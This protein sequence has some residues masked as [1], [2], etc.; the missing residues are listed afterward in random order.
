MEKRTLLAVV[1]S[2]LVI[3]A[4]Q[5]FLPSQSPVQPPATATPADKQ[6]PAEKQE[7]TPGSEKLIAPVDVPAEVKEITVDTDLYSAIFTTKGGTLK[8]WDLKGY[9]YKDNKKEKPVALVSPGMPAQPVYIQ[10][11]GELRD[12]PSIVN[13]SVDKDSVT[14]DSNSNTLT[15]YYADSSKGLSIKKMFTFYKDSFK[16]DLATEV[17]GVQS[18]KVALGSGFGIFDREGTWVHI[19]PVLLRDSKKIDLVS[20]NLEDIGTIKKWLTGKKSSDTV[21]YKGNIRWIAEEDKY[22]TSA[23]VSLSKDTEAVVW[24]RE[25]AGDSKNNGA[26]IAYVVNGEK[27]DF[28]L[29]AGPKRYELLKTFNVG[30]EHIIDFGFFSIIARPL[31]WLLKFFY[32]VIG[33]YGWAIIALT[34]VTRIPFIPLINKGQKSMKKLQEIQPHMTAL[35]EKY[36]NDPQ[37]MQKEV[38]E[39]Y[40]KHKVNPVGGCLPMLIQLP[41]FFALY[42]ILLI[43]IEL[44]GTPFMWWI[45]DLSMK[46]PYYILPIIMGITMVIQQKMTPS[47]MDPTQAKM[48]ML[49]P[50][51]FTFM[52]LSFP[53]G[54]VIYWL[55]SNVL[56]IVQQYYVNKKAASSA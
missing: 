53:S 20:G 7:I 50:V 22:F 12:L 31:F 1:L 11:D 26:D 41:V 8:K 51:I 35:K 34:V 16:V 36:K 4:S 29:Y 46:D 9:S 19:G 42:K 32:D 25:N 47:T 54:L 21:Q 18:Y 24:D 33:N 48:M 27:G 28:L 2:I 6:I 37:K 52:F 23:L 10:L 45:K 40:K 38:M 30:L 13:Y 15:F 3:I 44:R 17:K 39:I 56:G 55:V 5:Y 14:F 43:A 49:M